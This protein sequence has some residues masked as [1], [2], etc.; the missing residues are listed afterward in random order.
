[1]LLFQDPKTTGGLDGPNVSQRRNE[2]EKGTSLNSLS[3]YN[4]LDYLVLSV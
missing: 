4:P 2:E 3:L 1:M